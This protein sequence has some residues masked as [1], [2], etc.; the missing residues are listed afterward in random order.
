VANLIARNPCEGLLPVTIGSVTISEVLIDRMASVAPFRGK[1]AAVSEALKT[2]CGIAFP[3]PNRTTSKG[4]VRAVWA[5]Q[6]RANLIG[7]DLPDLS[8]LAAVTDQGDGV[9]AVKIEGDGAEAV[10]ARLVPLDLRAASFKRG[11]TARSLV[12]H[13]TASITRLGPKS[14]EVMVMRSMAQTLVHE[15]TEAAE[16]VAARG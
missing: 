8:G 7:C 13:M 15:L 3:A 2:A 4:A 11:H 6:G 5:G 14:F 9:A 12:N 16:G 1:E 10:L